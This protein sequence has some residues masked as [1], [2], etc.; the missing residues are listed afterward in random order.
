MGENIPIDKK[1]SFSDNQVIEFTFE[2]IGIIVKGN[3]RHKDFDHKY[4]LISNEE[5]G[6]G[7]KLE[8]E[9]YIDDKLSKTMD[10][11]VYF[12]ERSHELFYQYE[13]PQGKHKMKMSIKNPHEKIYLNV[14]GAY[15][16]RKIES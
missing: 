3:V 15:T 13:L 9:F 14:E 7:Y 2:G 11:P 6:D 12:I 4:A 1:V 8:V 10:L 16:Y 5:T